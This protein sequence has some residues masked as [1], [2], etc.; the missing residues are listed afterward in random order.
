MSHY[1]EKHKRPISAYAFGHIDRWAALGSIA[2]QE[3]IRQNTRRYPLH[4][5]DLLKMAI[6]EE[7]PK[8]GNPEVRLVKQIRSEA[9]MGKLKAGAAFS[10][11]L[12]SAA[13]AWWAWSD[14]RRRRTRSETSSK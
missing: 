13:F 7:V 14:H 3:Q 11:L 6:K 1:Y 5:A 8:R 4:L 12:G 2:P 9:S 10:A